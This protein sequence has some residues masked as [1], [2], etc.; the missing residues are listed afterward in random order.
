MATTREIVYRLIAQNDPSYKKVFSDFS[1][2]AVKAQEQITKAAQKGA[3]DRADAAKQEASE[4][5]KADARTAREKE[6]DDAALAKQ[7]EASRRYLDGEVTKQY[8]KRQAEKRDMARQEDDRVKAE[9]AGQRR[10]EAAHQAAANKSRQAFRDMA[11][12]STRAGEGM[13]R[14]VRAAVLLGGENDNMKK[15]VEQ[16]RL[17]QGFFDLYKG[18]VDIV[19]GLSKAYRAVA[20]AAAA[21]AAAQAASAA[22]GKAQA[23]SAAMSALPSAAS[24]LPAASS[25]APRLLGGAARA[26]K[27]GALVLG[28]GT[29][30]DRIFNKGRISDAIAEWGGNFAV[31]KAHDIGIL[32]LG[33]AAA[34]RG[35]TRFNERL[36][37]QSQL[38]EKYI[39]DRDM[40]AP[41]E[42]V[43]DAARRD[44][45]QAK[46]AEGLEEWRQFNND[47]T[48]NARGRVR[49][50]GEQRAAGVPV[51]E[52]EI[53][54]QQQKI[55]DLT[56]E[57]LAIEQQ[58]RQ[59][60]IEGMQKELEGAQKSLEMARQRVDMLMDSQRSMEERWN[61][62]T[63]AERAAAIA[64]ARAVSS[65]TGT[66]EDID[67]LKGMGAG[68]FLGDEMARQE[69]LMAQKSGVR[70]FFDASTFT[71]EK[72]QAMDDLE[73]HSGNVITLDN[74]IKVKITADV[75]EMAGLVAKV[76][77]PEMENVA[78]LLQRVEGRDRFRSENKDVQDNT[79]ANGGAGN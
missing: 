76:L 59:A 79:S 33:R 42:E 10:L 55:V 31:E 67:R 71:E 58:I 23:G 19:M 78:A 14:L 44:V 2:E 77:K 52:T 54:D 29:I 20:A 60:K 28:A 56:K 5:R 70:A 40:N 7:Q 32:D 66:T 4:R 1:K 37:R 39:R 15:F 18:V 72:G 57:K 16:L 27:A 62:M 13:M 68:A 74:Q 41:I 24:G 48:A 38:E 21:A 12:G 9:I 30:L 45:F 53:V 25:A 22:A 46:G 64:S 11:E 47:A 35:R 43:I 65:G 75:E 17:A 36:S 49:Q 34:N 73:K 63:D 6:R 51:A 8:K 69:R 61:R 50:L 3:R 26:G